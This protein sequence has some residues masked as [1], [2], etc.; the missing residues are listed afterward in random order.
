MKLSHECFNKE[1]MK[2]L[3]IAHVAPLFESVPPKLYG[4]TERVVSFLTEELIRMGHEVTLFASGDSTTHANLVPV[5]EKALRL[6][7]DCVDPL[8]HHIVQLQMVQELSHNFHVVHYHTDY[9]HYPLSRFSPVAHL[10]TL[11]GRLDIPELKPLYNLFRD[12]PV[13]SIS[14]NQRSPFPDINW[15]GN[16]YHGLPVDLLM[17]NFS[18][19]QY[20]A[21][22]GRISPEKGIDNAI[23]IARRCGIPLRI[24]A[25]IDKADKDYFDH[26]IKPLLDDP[27]IEYVGEIGEN[28]KGE[29]L[30]N[31]MALLFPIAWPEPFGLVMI[32]SLACGTPVIAYDRGSVP[33]ILEHGK[34]GFI[35]SSV[36]E[37]VEA[38]RNIPYIKREDCRLAFEQRFTSTIMA[39]AYV[40]LYKKILNV[41]ESPIIVNY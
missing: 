9:L 27:M 33:E 41:S 36:D 26:K 39:S 12:V 2:K 17:P 28:E 29:F 4:G 19:G 13:V 8:S 20:L 6:D 23:A 1:E 30:G 11:H 34:T 18:Q 25:K 31:A 35:V 40:N 3:R 10:T 32:E 7:P 5:C 21:F 22:L 38:V 37:G 14:E 15:V 16:V 24:A